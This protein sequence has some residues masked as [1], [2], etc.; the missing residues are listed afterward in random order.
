ME[1]LDGQNILHNNQHDF[2]AKRSCETLLLV[3]TD[4]IAKHLNKEKQVDMG[5]LDFSKAF[6]RFL[7]YQ[8][9]KQT[10]S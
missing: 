6:D 4:D 3:T 1:L 10:T 8:I 5:I 2:R 7:I 9:V